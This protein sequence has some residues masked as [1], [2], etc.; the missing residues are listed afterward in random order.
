MSDFRKIALSS[1]Y[2]TAMNYSIY[3]TN[4]FVQAA[5]ARFLV[6]DDY[7]NFALAASIIEVM[8][9]IFALDFSTAALQMGGMDG[10]YENAAALCAMNMAALLIIGG[11]SILFLRAHF[12][13][14]VIDVFCMVFFFRLFNII[15]KLYLTFME[16]DFLFLKSGVLRGAVRL[17]SL[18]TGLGMAYAGFGIYS[19]V[20]AEAINCFALFTLSVLFSPLRLKLRVIDIALA[21]KTILQS[22][23]LLSYRVSNVLFYRLPNILIGALTH[24]K[25]IIGTLDRGLYWAGLPTTVTAAFHSQILFVFFSGKQGQKKALKDSLNWALWSM[26]RLSICFSLII[27]FYTEGFVILVLG[28]NWLSLIPILKMLSMYSFFLLLYNIMIQ[29]YI[30][31][32]KETVLTRLQHLANVAL[33]LTILSIFHFR[34]PWTNLSMVFSLTTA[35]LFL[36]L[37]LLIRDSEIKVRFWFVFK[38]PLVLGVASA[39]LIAMLN[40]SNIY[41]GAGIIIGTFMLVSAA[42]D[43]SDIMRLARML[44]RG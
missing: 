41:Y 25:H 36:A 6:P 20:A 9:V 37:S 27:Y 40:V 11:V 4:I 38:T 34:L 21:K 28:K 8:F 31:L 29:L 10:I 44:R 30:G 5:T 14:V 18:F 42:L 24:D 39:S 22:L 7:G 33:V 19:L 17:C 35:F 23:K 26:A 2:V 1:V 3:F 12:D 43:G 15:S 16:K 13:R 32:K